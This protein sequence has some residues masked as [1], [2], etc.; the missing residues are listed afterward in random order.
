MIR[1]GLPVYTADGERMGTVDHL[2]V[3][4]QTHR[5]THLV[6][7]RGRWFSPGEDY[8]VSIDHVTT[9][10]EYGIRLR[11]RHDEIEQLP[12]YHPAANDAEIQAQ[13]ERS[14]ETQPET[15]G[16]GVRVEV[17][18]GLV[19]LL[20]EVSEAVAQGATQLARWMRGV[21]GSK[22][23]P[24]APVH[25]ASALARRCSHGR[26]YWPSGQSGH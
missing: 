17:E 11:L 23:G 22:I 7:H 6:I 26:T 4:P 13:I 19:R 3:D 16:Q 14:L 24:R 1:R 15:R 9:A 18:R 8:M 21:S 2:L 10:S 5:V 25:L 20:G 12:R